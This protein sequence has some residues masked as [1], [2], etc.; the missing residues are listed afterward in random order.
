MGNKTIL[1]LGNYRQI[2]DLNA[3]PNLMLGVDGGVKEPLICNTFLFVFLSLLFS[4]YGYPF[5]LKVDSVKGPI[6]D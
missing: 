4:K 2:V 5:S 3:H 1:Y 6:L